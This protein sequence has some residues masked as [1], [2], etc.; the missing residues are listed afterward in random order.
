M[1]EQDFQAM[2]DLWGYGAYS[3]FSDL[4]KTLHTQM[5]RL[6]GGLLIKTIQ[7]D[8]FRILNTTLGDNSDGGDDKTAHKIRVYSAHDTTLTG[9]FVALDNYNFL[10]PPYASCAIFELY[11]DK[12][13]KLFYRNDS[14]LSEPAELQLCRNNVL[15]VDS[16]ACLLQEW[17]AETSHLVV[18][19]EEE[20]F[21]EC[22][23]VSNTVTNSRVLYLFTMLVTTWLGIVINLVYKLLNKSQVNSG[24][25]HSSNKNYRNLDHDSEDEDRDQ[26]HEEENE[27][28]R[29]NK[30]RS[31]SRN[32]DEEDLALID[33]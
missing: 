21:S 3:I 4:E 14:S 8:M 10:Q 17:V 31:S 24:S 22:G 12:S 15:G 29:K 5:S 20:F 23:R 27:R 25:S 6:N 7:Q 19:D 2:N 28:R 11:D 16:D 30:T 18:N 13:L 9:L 32:S 1:T 33:R 26:E